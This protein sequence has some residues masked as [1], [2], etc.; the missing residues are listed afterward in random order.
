MKTTALLL[1]AP[2]GAAMKVKVFIL[3]GQSNMEGHGVATK[4]R[5]A[6]DGNGTVQWEVEHGD[7]KKLPVC[8]TMAEQTAE[9]GCRAEHA[10]F[11]GL[12]T[13]GNWTVF[14]DAF[15][16]FE[17]SRNKTGPLSVGFGISDDFVG[18][19][20]GF[21][22]S[23]QGTFDDQTKV[24]LLKWAWGGTALQ[25]DWR[26]PSSGGVLGWCYGNMTEVVHRVLDTGL[27]SVVPGYDYGAD[28]YDIAGF[29]WHQG[30]NDGCGDEGTKEYE[31]NLRNLIHDVRAEFGVANLPVSI[32]LSGFG[33]WGQ[34]VDRRLEI[35]RAQYNV[36]TYVANVATVETRGFFRDFTETG[37][38]INQG[39]HWFGNGETY[40]YVGTAMGAAMNALLAGTWVQPKI[41]YLPPA[42]GAVSCAS[43]FACGPYAD[44]EPLCYW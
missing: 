28:S 10:D 16:H 13:D 34:G 31:A 43:A 26:P 37:G 40:V 27:P 7:W 9:V 25:T 32:G 22:V 23:L 42:G 2:L 14:D 12:M 24:L 15:V 18:P 39:Y 21:G 1:L 35:M 8:P 30:W 20:Y 6:N 41:D 33:G 3:A 11:D 17:G 38:C 36:S 44:G 4:S 19:E 5:G 29:A